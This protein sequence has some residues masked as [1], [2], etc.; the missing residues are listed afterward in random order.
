MNNNPSTLRATPTISGNGF[1]GG[2]SYLFCHHRNGLY[3]T[4][5]DNGHERFES[6]PFAERSAHLWDGVNWEAAGR[7]NLD[8][9]HQGAE[10]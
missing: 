5:N 10:S 9:D 8:A 6:Y 1:T 7:F 3:R 4:T 2:K